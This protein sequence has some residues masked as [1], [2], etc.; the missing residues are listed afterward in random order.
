MHPAQISWRDDGTPVSRDFGDVY[1]SSEDGL[2]ESRH[3]F[4][5]GNRLAERW[6]RLPKDAHF[7]IIESGFGT[8]LN[9]LATWQ[10]WKQVAPA[11][12]RL[13]FISIEKHPLS[14]SDLELALARWPELRELASGLLQSYPLALPGLHQLQ[15]EPA[16]A[17]TLGFGDIVET[18]DGLCD[19]DHPALRSYLGIRADAWMLDGFAPARN[20]AMW[21]SDVCE[22][23]A[24]LSRPGTS[25]AT[26]TAAGQVRRGLAAMGFK[27]DKV[28]GHG[29]KRDMLV[30]VFDGP[31]PGGSNTRRANPGWHCTPTPRFASK[32]A[33]VIGA[34]LAGCHTARAL[35]DSGWRVKVLEQDEA[36]A[37][38]ASG[39]PAGILYTRLTA[40]DS[41][42]GAF[43]LEAYLY[44][45]RHYRAG[46][47][48]GLLR[49]GSDGVLNG[50][51][52]LGFSAAE[53]HAIK[54]IADRY[55]EFEELVQYLD[56]TEASVRAGIPVDHPALFFPDSGWLDP[57]AIC[58]RLL[59]HPAIE[60]CARR[61]V[62]ELL[63]VT[64]GWQVQTENAATVSAAACIITAGID[65]RQ[66]RQLATLPTRGVGGQVSFLPR[67]VIRPKLSICHNGYLAP[68]GGG[69]LCFGATFRIN[70][71]SA[72]LRAGDHQQNLQ[73]LRD[74]LP[75]LLPTESSR[76]SAMEGLQGRAGVRCTTP[77]RLPIVGPAPDL[78][79]MLEVF[80]PL[81]KNA[82]A[83][84]D[85][86]G[87]FLP[88]LYV[89]TGH[90]S[91]G[92]ATTPIAAACIAALVNQTPR[93][94]HWKL[95]RAISPAR[96]AIRALIKG[97]DR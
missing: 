6:G 18:L 77:D 65:S 56:A 53:R 87:K 93:P 31:L 22:R 47:A 55:R 83:R 92:L 26:F 23:I 42:A 46:F 82:R 79:S 49:K 8:G 4:L 14:R 72:E 97:K 3:V 80:R 34:G 17:L 70:D 58:G 30:G 76:D 50:M 5:Q 24:S 12:A 60:F 61:R 59:M 69:G 66:F 67:A 43:S 62:L 57:R 39:N 29:R 13:H 48:G 2:G 36:W 45:T 9:F 28:P 96:F 37:R 78:E 16:V 91:R 88:G 21:S 75:S 95:M 71:A 27:V 85:Q 94:L 32:T 1:F 40:G 73:Q 33:I 20:P 44:A 35:A 15:L 74:N 41:E 89:N 63:P 84:V 52:Q 51:L 25:F 68:I 19:C 90:G 10:L 86:A 64:R 7:I 38:G 81:A 54:R 11:D